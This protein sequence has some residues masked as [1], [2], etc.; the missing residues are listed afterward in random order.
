[1]KTDLPLHP[2]ARILARHP[3]GILA[4][5]KPAGLLTHPNKPGIAHN[6]LLAAGYDV[7]TETYTWDGGS[8]HLN[9]RLDSPTSGIVLACLDPK[10]SKAVNDLFR[11][12]RVNKD[13]L[14]IA[15]GIPTIKRGDWEDRI[16][17]GRENGKIRVAK[18]GGGTPARTTFELM[19]TSRKNRPISL[20]KLTPHTGRTHQLRV[21]AALHRFPI[22]GDRNYG[23]FGFNRQ[24]QKETGEKRLF[25][26][27]HRIHLPIPGGNEIF[28]AESPMPE[29]FERVLGE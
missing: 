5:E 22:V 24:F 3:S 11:Q 19:G 23:D 27:A 9:N 29:A 21:Q 20:L 1:M 15:K 2:D 7:K 17:R 12:K 26:H 25:L 6:A 16:A 8:L 10:T 13:Y 28:T 14:A 18:G 4:I